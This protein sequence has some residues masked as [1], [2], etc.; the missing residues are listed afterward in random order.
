VEILERDQH[1][2]SRY[3]TL[4]LGQLRSSAASMPTNNT[5]SKFSPLAHASPPVQPRATK[6]TVLA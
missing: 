4:D 5:Q 6:Q 1:G 2:L 3:D